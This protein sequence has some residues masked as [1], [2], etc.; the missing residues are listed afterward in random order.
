MQTHQVEQG[1][2][3]MSTEKERGPQQATPNAVM[4]VRHTC[5]RYG[6]ALVSEEVQELVVEVQVTIYPERA[7]IHIIAYAITTNELSINSRQW[8]GC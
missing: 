1:S 8:N 2:H 5:G 6:P 3:G 4:V 7:H